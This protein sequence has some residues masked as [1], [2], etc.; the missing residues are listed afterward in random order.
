MRGQIVVSK[1]FPSSGELSRAA[2]RGDGRPESWSEGGRTHE[3]LQVPALRERGGGQF[4]PLETAASSLSA[5]P[6]A[7]R[8]TGPHPLV[9]TGKGLMQSRE[10]ASLY[11][12]KMWLENSAAW[13]AGVGG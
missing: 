2:A 11:A 6:G 1:G 13:G 10:G 4:G 5:R 7:Q 9:A 12:K 8:G 3:A